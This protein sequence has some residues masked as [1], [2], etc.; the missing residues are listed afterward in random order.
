M[1]TP[2]SSSSKF[3]KCPKCSL[4]RFYYNWC[5][6]CEFYAYQTFYPK[7]TCQNQDIDL[8]IKS[9]QANAVFEY[10][11]GAQ[12]PQM[13]KWERS[14]PKKVTLKSLSG[15]QNVK[16]QFFEELRILSR[17]IPSNNTYTISGLLRCYGI[18]RD[19]KTHEFMMVFQH[20]SQYDLQTYLSRLPYT[21][22]P[23]SHKLISQIVGGLK[24]IHESGLIHKN[25][26]SGNILIDENGDAYIG[27]TGLCKPVDPAKIRRSSEP[28]KLTFQIVNN[29]LRPIMIEDMPTEYKKLISS[30]LDSDPLNRPSIEVIEKVLNE[31]ICESGMN[32]ISGEFCEI[33][34]EVG[35]KG[36][37]GIRRVL[38]QERQRIMPHRKA[39]YISRLIPMLNNKTDVNEIKS[40]LLQLQNS[41]NG[42]HDL[43]NKPDSRTAGDRHV[44]S[45]RTSSQS[46]P[47]RN[48]LIS[49]VLENK[50]S[51]VV[52]LNSAGNKQRES[53]IFT[54]SK[55]SPEIYYENFRESREWLFPTNNHIQKLQTAA[56]YQRI[57]N[58]NK[59]LIPKDE[60][61]R[62]YT[63]FT[64]QTEIRV[65]LE[66]NQ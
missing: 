12:D 61:F 7:W 9:I 44:N 41:R 10:K 19:P 64:G 47:P 27:D 23:Q 18:T 3:G 60:D 15:S 28:I 51:S 21:T 55:Q 40:G 11:D 2:Q 8:V 56:A 6:Q 62:M 24:E 1:S 5:R 58:M 66:Q 59:C 53:C 32:G 65:N 16:S 63:G 50:Q 42:S 4:P 20:C 31:M 33:G 13:P 37:G 57:S 14:G 34:L 46:S 43:T 35:I 17:H 29:N 45:P 38:Y 25:L 22:F 26:H 49:H 36:N 39:K 48:S 30:C 52:I 54:L